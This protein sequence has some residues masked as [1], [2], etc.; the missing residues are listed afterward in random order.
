MSVF[1]MNFFELPRNSGHMVNKNW[2][3]HEPC[4]IK[5]IVKEKL[6]QAN[7]TF[8]SFKISKENSLDSKG[9]SVLSLAP[10]DHEEI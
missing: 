1:E 6:C 4:V 5:D 3:E 7:V 2:K 10:I 8:S 9:F